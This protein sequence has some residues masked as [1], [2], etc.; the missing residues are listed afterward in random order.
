MLQE[1]LS[2]QGSSKLCP[3]ALIVRDGKFL[4]GFRHYTPAKWK[5][6]SVWT[7][8]GGRCDEGETLE[9]TVRREVK[10][11]T[12]ITNL[13]IVEYLGEVKGAYKDD[14]VPLFYCR[15]R[16][17]AKL[18]EP[19]KFS[20]WRWVGIDNLPEN[21]INGDVAKLVREFLNK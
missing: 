20:E 17:D 18:M 9:E 13:E 16:E 4:I 15:T 1:Q 6:I 14:R 8:P 11:E 10:E 5:N 21:F 7:F 12:G 19:E 2:R 3:G